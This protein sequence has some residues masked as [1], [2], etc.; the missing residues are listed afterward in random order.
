MTEA[1]RDPKIAVLI[2]V[3]NEEKVL[4]GTIDALVAAGVPRRDIY[5]VNDKSTDTTEEVAKACWVNVFTVRENGGKARAQ[6]QA[7]EHF[8]LCD[9]YDWVIFVDGDTKV[10]LRFYEEMHL[11]ARTDPSVALYVGQVKSVKNDHAYSAT[12]AV[13]YAYG[14]DVAKH[15]QSN[16]NVIIVS[17]GCSSMYRADILRQLHIDHLTLAED[18]DLTIQ[19]HRLGG[20]VKYLPEAAVHTQDPATL[21][22]YLK[23]MLRWYRGFW[24]VVLKH[25][26]FGWQRKQGVDLYMMLC[27][28]DATVL[29]R[30]LWIIGLLCFFPKQ[31]PSIIGIDVGIMFAVTTYGAWRT[32]R[33]DVFKWFPV[34][35]A[36][37][38]LSVA[39]YLRAFVEIIVLRKQILAWNRV[40]RYDY[41]NHLAL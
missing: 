30:V 1:V 35:Y 14:Q 13:E 38:F 2:P 31:A 17:P 15:G 3:Y 29:N 19:V 40:A 32:K 8:K 22:D 39:M 26:I 37:G 7:L 34:S 9:R 25:R 24:Q 41:S 23:Q 27:I 16:F 4:K 10:D 6:V 5:V 33:L 36:V 11:A 28:F 18:M 21:K 12:R 20:R